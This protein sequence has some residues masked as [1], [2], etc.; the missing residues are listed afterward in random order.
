MLLS[1]LDTL[2]RVLSND[3]CNRA[4]RFMFASDRRDFI[5][6]HALLRTTMSEFATTTASEWRF[7][8]TTDGKPI[9]DCRMGTT[10]LDFNISHTSGLVACVVAR[11]IDVGIDVER[12]DRGVNANDVAPF[13][14]S[15]TECSNLMT[16][17]GPDQS[18]RFIELWTLK[19]AYLKGLGCGFAIPPSAL[20]FHTD[21]LGTIIC[22]SQ[23]HPVSRGWH[24]EVSMPSSGYRLAVAAKPRTK[25][26]GRVQTNIRSVEHYRLKSC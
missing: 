10:Y 22:T 20:S 14:L 5:A 15:P 16:V 25:G 6:A 18:A 21:R 12:V 4:A 8:T 3:E 23:L 7:K 11:N 19:E 26:L 13:C 9:V 1:S 2:T 17:R 24:F